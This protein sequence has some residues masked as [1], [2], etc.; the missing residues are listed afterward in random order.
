MEMSLKQHGTIVEKKIKSLVKKINHKK[1][2]EVE[3]EENKEEK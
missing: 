3:E 2:E 1:M